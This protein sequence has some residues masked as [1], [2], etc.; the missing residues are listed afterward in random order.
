MS[1]QYEYAKAIDYGGLQKI[2]FIEQNAINVR[3]V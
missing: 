3:R 2:I 1:R